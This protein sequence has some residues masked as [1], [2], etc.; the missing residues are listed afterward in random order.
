MPQDDLGGS[1]GSSQ[2]MIPVED[3]DVVKDAPI[4]LRHALELELGGDTGARVAEAVTRISDL[5]LRVG[6]VVGGLSNLPAVNGAA[7]GGDRRDFH[8]REKVDGGIGASGTVELHRVGLACGR[9]DGQ[10]GGEGA[11]GA[12]SCGRGVVQMDGVHALLEG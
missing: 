1:R 8:G 3:D 5:L 10:G 9:V 6:A 11:L 2:S 4:L 12:V 7:G